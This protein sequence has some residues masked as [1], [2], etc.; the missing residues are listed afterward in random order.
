MVKFWKTK[1][2]E[3]YNNRDFSTEKIS[4]KDTKCLSHGFNYL[5]FIH[6]SPISPCFWFP[7]YVMIEV[8][9]CQ[10]VSDQHAKPSIERIF[11]QKEFYSKAK[12]THPYAWDLLLYF[13]MRAFT[14]SSSEV[15][16]NSETKIFLKIYLWEK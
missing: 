3:A 12:I 2:F 13:K 15:C 1:H 4:A 6:S 11:V 16:T 5:H 8:Q 7:R 10:R 9:D 14:D